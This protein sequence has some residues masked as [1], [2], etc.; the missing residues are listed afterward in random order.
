MNTPR[1]VE[2]LENR[3]A[4]EDPREAIKRLNHLPEE[5]LDHIVSF[6]DQDPPSLASNPSE[7]SIEGL[8]KIEC[9]LKALS[10]TSKAWRKKA[11]PRLFQ[12]L[13]LSFEMLQG[14]A[15]YES[16]WEA[17]DYGLSTPGG[18]TSRLQKRRWQ[19]SP[20]QLGFEARLVGYSSSKSVTVKKDNGDDTE[21]A[22][23]SLS[24]QDQEY[25]ELVMDH[26]APDSFVLHPSD[27]N[28]SIK[29][30]PALAKRY[31]IL[32]VPLS[33]VVYTSMD[34]SKASYD[35]KYPG[36]NDWA[37]STTWMSALKRL[38]PDRLVLIAPPSTIAAM[39]DCW[40]DIS[41]AWAFSIPYQRVELCM[42]VF[43]PARPVC[44][45]S[46]WLGS[47]NPHPRGSSCLQRSP[48]LW[49]EDEYRST[50]KSSS[51]ILHACHWKSMEYDEGSS[52]NAYGTYH[53]F[54][55]VSRLN[56]HTTS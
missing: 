41:D 20:S 38:N 27:D 22:W 5:L 10:L 12:Y 19:D 44:H 49:R 17:K 45:G 26:I 9:P 14:G 21:I 7:P 3:L 35:R 13:R 48:E 4:M 50:S 11:A 53:Y 54:E 8:F 40:S 51:G 36:Y 42:P 32:Q 16:E 15:S 47:L 43:E 37:E 33:L 1:P 24:E 18:E 52:L 34:T 23:S 6:L 2:L 55:K 29:R 28:F 39:T 56:V 31:N 25:A 30:F 46:E